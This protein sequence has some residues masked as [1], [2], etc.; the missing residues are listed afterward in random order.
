MKKFI[1]LSGFFLAALG[2]GAQVTIGSGNVPSEWSLLDI[3]TSV[4]KKGLHSPR[5]DNSQREDLI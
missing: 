2:A 5:L 4:Q 1:F 3:D